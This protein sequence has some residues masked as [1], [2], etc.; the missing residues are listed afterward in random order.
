MKDTESFLYKNEN[1]ESMHPLFLALKLHSIPVA[2]SFPI[3]NHPIT[4]AE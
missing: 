2:N 1:N 3:D 4:F